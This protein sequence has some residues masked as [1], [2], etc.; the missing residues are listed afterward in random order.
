MPCH[1]LCI[2]RGWLSCESSRAFASG[3]SDGNAFGKLDTRTDAHLYT[4][5][6]NEK[7][8]THEITRGHVPGYALKITNSI[9]LRPIQM[10]I[11]S[12]K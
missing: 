6:R 2:G 10:R 7:V 5:V 9:L 8:T 1:R 11:F 4:G 3:P 12:I